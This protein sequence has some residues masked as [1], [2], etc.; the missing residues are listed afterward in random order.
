MIGPGGVRPCSGVVED[1]LDLL[2]YTDSITRFDISAQIEFV[3]GFNPSNFEEVERVVCSFLGIKP[4]LIDIACQLISNCLTSEDSTD[5]FVQHLRSSGIESHL[6]SRAYGYLVLN[7]R[8]DLALSKN[9]ETVQPY[10]QVGFTD[11]DDTSVQEVA[12][13]V[14]KKKENPLDSHSFPQITRSRKT[15]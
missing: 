6:V 3:V 9:M 10:F 15:P 7:L 1:I 5:V 12:G 11:L 4:V 2:E 8:I 14:I 13:S